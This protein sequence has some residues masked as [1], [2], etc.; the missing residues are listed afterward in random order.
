MKEALEFD[1]EP[2]ETDGLVFERE[3]P[4]GLVFESVKDEES[5]R[6]EAAPEVSLS[7]EDEN[8]KSETP[9]PEAAAAES[10]EFGIPETFEVNEKYNKPLPT[11]E[12]T[13]IY[14]TYVPRFTEASEN[15]RMKNDPRPPI[16]KEEKTERLEV[17]TSVTEQK[18]AAEPK[19]ETAPVTEPQPAPQTVVVSIPAESSD[20]LDGE[21]YSIFKFG[22][23][24][25]GEDKQTTA[26]ENANR[27]A[28]DELKARQA[29]RRAREEAERLERELAEREA[30]RARARIRLSP[31]DYTMPDPE[32]SSY[33][34]KRNG[35]DDDYDAPHGIP[36]DS[37]PQRK[38]KL[39]EYKRTGQRDRFKDRFLDLLVS[40]RI[41]LCLAVLLSLLLLLV[42]NYTFVGLRPE[43]WFDWLSSSASAIAII[44]LQLTACAVLLA[45][46]EICR[47]MKAL[48][49]RELRPEISL[50]IS[51]AVNS[52]YTVIKVSFRY[53]GMPDFGF[54]ISVGAVLALVA[55]C[56]QRKADFENFKFISEEGEKTVVEY[57]QTR[58][59]P[60]VMLSLDGAVDGY[61]SSIAKSFRTTFVSDFFKNSAK[62]AENTCGNAIMLAISLLAAACASIISYLVADSGAIERA[63]CAFA[64][65]CVFSVPAITLISHKL[66][67]RHACREALAADCA[68]IGEAAYVDNS[69]IDVIAFEDTE[70]F[71][72]DDVNL[73]RFVFYSSEES[74]NKFMRLVSSLFAAVGGP[75]YSIFSKAL[76]KRCTPATDIAIEADGI[77]GKVDGRAVYVGGADYMLRR[78]IRIP[79]D[80]DRTYGIGA[81]S[82]KTM[83]GAED[84]AVFA[85]FLI[86]YSFSEE[87]TSLQP[88]L[89]DEK[90]VPLIYTSD[91]NVSAEL[92]RMLTMGVDAVR[93]MR[94]GEVS[95][96]AE[97]VYPRL[98][99]ASVTRGDP[100]SAIKLVLI[101]K[102]YARF[103]KHI[104]ATELALAACGAAAATVICVFGVL[105]SVPTAV[106]G[107]F[108]ALS[109]AVLG[110]VSR[111]KF[112]ISKKNK[113]K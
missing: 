18:P 107:L 60:R 56:M 49:R 84:G 11:Q 45:S 63:V 78:G 108:G 98:D 38:R 92:V 76:E 93:V 71:G 59:Y 5:A 43:A 28:L 42:E 88:L 83:Y 33:F 103:I 40:V 99:A 1:F 15:Y 34:D 94:R 31:E 37:E 32:H 109:A 47:A 16:R 46:P 68:V 29:E 12:R 87:F 74:M 53:V 81:E 54:I 23:P 35:G 3:E 72:E 77:S 9:A 96:Y 95:A 36:N 105:A 2:E 30:A 55:S 51:F 85:R 101:S 8:S 26:E 75:L 48:T 50:V 58:K 97:R 61:R 21:S 79:E 111:R 89:R 82:M 44:D 41:R 39:S 13:R 112:N 20:S 113:G 52:V 67:Y 4:A 65:V 6:E 69:R 73:K 80:N 100:V 10:V 90:I 25:G 66:T 110:F 62:K 104:S 14:T 7:P 86:R 91:P 106:F 64:F 22:S 102:R 27:R 17:K 19:E 70:I 57:E 24:D